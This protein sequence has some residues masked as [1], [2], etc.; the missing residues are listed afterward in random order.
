MEI[1]IFKKVTNMFIFQY[2]QFYIVNNM[3]YIVYQRRKGVI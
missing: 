2:K 1:Q 3:H